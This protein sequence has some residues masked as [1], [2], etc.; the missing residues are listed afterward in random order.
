MPAERIIH[1]TTK[2]CSY[3]SLRSAIIRAVLVADVAVVAVVSGDKA[4]QSEE[5]IRKKNQKYGHW[6]GFLFRRGCTNCT[7]VCFLPDV[8]VSGKCQAI[9]VILFHI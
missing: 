8:L 3:I 1:R 2:E 7:P 9:C 4:S 6:V 5:P